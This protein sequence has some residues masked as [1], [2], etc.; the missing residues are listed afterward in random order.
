MIADETVQLR[1]LCNDPGNVA[2]PNH[3][4]M[5][6]GE[7]SMREC[8]IGH[9]RSLGAAMPP[10]VL[11]AEPTEALLGV[12]VDPHA[13]KLKGRLWNRRFGNYFIQASRAEVHGLV[14]LYWTAFGLAAGHGPKYC[15]T[16]DLEIVRHEARP[17]QGREHE[18]VEDLLDARMQDA[19]LAVVW[20]GEYAKKRRSDA[21]AS[22]EEMLRLRGA[23]RLT[24]IVDSPVRSFDRSSPIWS[25]GLAHTLGAA[26][27]VVLPGFTQ[28]AEPSETSTPA[29]VDEKPAARKAVPAKFPG[30]CQ[31]CG[32]RIQAGDIMVWLDANRNRAH[33]GCQPSP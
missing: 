32:K 10:V 31:I 24:W 23:H 9:L 6:H 13:P 16:S 2:L 19:D 8:P 11:R 28:R 22:V 33:E 5:V 12:V 26:T 27:R 17:F 4:Y 21:A 3:T 25:P 1:C 29:P 30:T 7:D 18:V 20:L 15:E 14:K